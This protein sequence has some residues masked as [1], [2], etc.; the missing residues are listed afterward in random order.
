ML[1]TR[2]LGGLGQVLVLPRPHMSM[3]KWWLEHTVQLWLTR[4]CVWTSKV[5]TSPRWGEQTMDTLTRHSRAFCHSLWCLL[6]SVRRVV[7]AG[8]TKCRRIAHFLG[9]AQTDITGEASIML[10]TTVCNLKFI[11]YFWKF[12]CKIT[13][14]VFCLYECLPACVC[15]CTTCMPGTQRSTMGAALRIS[16]ID[17]CLPICSH[18]YANDIHE[19]IRGKN[20]DRWK[21]A[22]THSQTSWGPVYVYM[23][24][25]TAYEVRNGLST[26]TEFRITVK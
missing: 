6:D 17:H 5:G 1:Y 23:S 14:F 13:G 8:C 2:V 22:C 4:T 18:F 10:F 19:V 24:L 12:P 25:E 21:K 20:N 15:V 16:W 26:I 9:E 3:L 11:N 7:H